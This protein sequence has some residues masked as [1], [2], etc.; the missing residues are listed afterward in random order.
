MLCMRYDRGK[1]CLLRLPRQLEED[2]SHLY[3]E[4]LDLIKLSSKDLCF[5]GYPTDRET[6]A[7]LRALDNTVQWWLLVGPLTEMAYQAAREND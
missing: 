1:S 7:F 3:Q 4:F 5:E 6:L 2:L